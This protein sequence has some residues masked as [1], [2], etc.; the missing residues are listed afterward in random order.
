MWSMSKPV[1]AVAVYEMQPHPSWTLATAL[2]RALRRSENCRERRVVLALQQLAHGPQGARNRFVSV[3]RRAGAPRSDLF[4]PARPAGLG[5]DP[6][7]LSYLGSAWP[8]NPRAPALQLGTATWYTR[9]A[10]RFALTLARGSY[11][12]AG[13]HVSALMQVPKAP[14]HDVDAVPAE[15]TV[16]S[17]SWGAGNAF[18]RW[19]PAYKSGWGGSNRHQFIVG[20][21]VALRVHGVPVGV[22]AMFHPSS[23]TASDDPGKTVGPEALEAIFG[24]IAESLP[25]VAARRSTRLR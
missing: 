16:S 4:V 7:C 8:Q 14:S 13:Q 1:S 9:D 22:M 6:A 2:A 15:Y 21:V 5:D 25:Y 18:H 12:T 23:P 10:V 3:L 17:Q 20:Q 24:E 19:R 11:G